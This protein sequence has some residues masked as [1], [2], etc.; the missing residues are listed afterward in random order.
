MISELNHNFSMIGVSETKIKLST[1]ELPN[2]IIPG[3]NFFSQPSLSNAGGVGIF[4]SKKISSS[5]RNDLSCSHNDFESLWIEIESDLHHNLICGVIYR[6]PNNNLE[7]FL[8]HLNYVVEKINSEN[9]YCTIVGDF[10]IDLLNSSHSTTEEFLNILE[11]N[12]FN[13]HILQ[14]TRITYHSATLIDNIF[15]NS[16]THHTISGNIIYDLTDHLPNF[17]IINKF[18][19]LP[20]DFKISR[21]NYSQFNETEFL[22][23]IQSTNWTKEFSNCDNPSELFNTFYIILNDIV[24]KHIPLQQLSAK[25]L[26]QLSK[27]W[28]TKGL[29]TSIDMKNKLYRKYLKNRSLYYHSKFKLYRNKLNHLIKISKTN[30]YKTYFISNKSNMKNT[31]KG[32]KE[33]IGYKNGNSNLPS[34]ILS[35]TDNKELTDCS[36]IANAFNEFFASV[37]KNISYSIPQTINSPLDF[38]PP[39]IA[40][41]FSFSSI[42]PNEIEE[43]INKLKAK[44]ATGPYSIP[45]S[46]LK[47]ISHLISKPLS[48]IFNASLSSGI[49]PENFKLAS[50]IPIFKKGSQ[51]IVNNYRPISLLSIF[52]RI[53]EKLVFNRMISFI[54]KKNILYDNQF[55]FRFKH[56]TT[57]AILTIVDKI[58]QAIEENTYSCGLF[59]D[60]TKAFDTVNHSI[61]IQKLDHY[62]IRSTA[63]KWFVSYLTNRKQFVSLGCT[64]SDTLPISCGVPQGSVL[65]PLLFLLYINDFHNSSPIFDFHIFADDS[66]LFC[67]HKNIESLESIINDQLSVVECWLSTNKLSLNIEKS[68][69]VIFHPVQKKVN[70]DV[71]IQINGKF[72]K[73]EDHIKYLGV[74]LDS[75]LSWKTHVS[76]ILKKLKRNIGLI[77]KARH[78]VNLQILVNL[79]YCLIYP[80]L[81][82]GIVVWGHTY[83]STIDPLIIIQKKVLRLITFSKFDAHSNPIFLQLQILKFPDLV[84]LYT[85][86]FMHDYYTKNLPISFSSYFVQV[87]K[88]H[89]YN[90]R[91]AVKSSYSLPQIRTNYG[92]FNIKYSGVKIWNSIDE[93]IKNLSKTK[94]KEILSSNILDSYDDTV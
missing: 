38:M 76:S 16:I 9:K 20:K 21:R 36:S 87:N 91:L 73:Q 55:G 92:K 27:P 59:L 2:Y 94:F 67:K 88:K 52:N 53:L 15:F 42:T 56:S 8:N 47:T 12:F 45:I 29:K 3:Y 93:S 66:N 43:E 1:E 33:I 57:H 22:N 62:G 41:D 49:V 35:S 51:L 48:V 64:K 6:H 61:L 14:P 37:G 74:M 50:V 70:Y 17:L 60:L 58:Q 31:W 25:E 34:K 84:Y 77:C 81:V 71:H 83:Q 86:L 78:Y 82:Y 68:N 80:Y 46:I 90:T 39:M 10:N 30:Y 5:L 32:I 44:K 89:C 40:D 4:I 11:T 54:N 65:G 7:S 79:Y 26:K 72:I 63:K 24:E 19:A 23:D 13:P 18:S 28:I 69:F 85:A 75:H